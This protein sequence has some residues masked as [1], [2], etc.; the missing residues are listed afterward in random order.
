V[1]SVGGHLDPA[2]T[3]WE[4]GRDA[5]TTASRETVL[6]YVREHLEV[7][8]RIVDSLYCATISDLGD[9]FEVRRNGSILALYGNNLFKLAPVLGDLLATACAN[10]ST[11]FV[12]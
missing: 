12:M 9:G 7:E 3:A 11:P 6:R 2:A 10:G 1:W 8:P 4:V 5:A